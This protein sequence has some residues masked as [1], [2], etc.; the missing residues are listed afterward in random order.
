MKRL[1][2]EDRTSYASIHE[3]TFLLSSELLTNISTSS[4]TS[5]CM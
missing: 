5:A 4:S 2:N 1:G 3:N